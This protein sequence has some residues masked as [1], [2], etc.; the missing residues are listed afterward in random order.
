ML[1]SSTESRDSLA[2]QVVTLQEKVTRL[3]QDKEHWMLESQLVQ[4]KLDKEKQVSLQGYADTGCERLR[5]AAMCICILFA[6]VILP[7]VLQ[8]DQKPTCMFEITLLNCLSILIDEESLWNIGLYQ[9]STCNRTGKKKFS[10][11]EKYCP[12]TRDGR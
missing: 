4:V 12:E 2:Q 7:P 11:A 10:C 9:Q 8:S 5:K 3:E 6:D 1:F